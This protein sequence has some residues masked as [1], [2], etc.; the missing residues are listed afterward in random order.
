MAAM[1]N[2]N[3]LQLSSRNRNDLRVDNKEK[4]GFDPKKMMSQLTSIYLNLNSP[5]LA[6]A[7]AKDEVWMMNAMKHILFL[8]KKIISRTR[9]R[10]SNFLLKL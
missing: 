5:E 9:S 3:L 7:I 4:Y 10:T 6:Q 8:I 2:Y 1:L